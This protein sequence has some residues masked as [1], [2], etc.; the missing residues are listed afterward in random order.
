MSHAKAPRKKTAPKVTRAKAAASAPA[1]TTRGRTRVAPF[2]AKKLRALDVELGAALPRVIASSDDEAIHDLRV[3][4]RRLRTLLKL[5]RP[6]YG[7]FHAD[8]VRRAFT[9]IQ[10][11]T[12]DLRDEEVLEETLDELPMEDEG[13]VAWKARRKSRERNLRRA[14]VQRL[15]AGDLTR[16]RAMLR[17]L[18][19]LPVKPARNKDLARFARKCVERARVRVDAQ[20]DVDPSDVVGMHELRIA[21]KELR[22]SAELLCEALPLDLRVLSEPAA[23]FQK[24]LGEVHDV[25]MALVTARRARG[26]NVHV[27]AASI[28]LLEKL[29]DKKVAKYV[30]EM[31]PAPEISEAQLS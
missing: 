4:I 18:L 30:A 28:E 8:A 25:D 7:R 19:A 5:S 21:F 3:A 22:Y 10:S 1:P 24:R 9:E 17:G 6:V 11:A 20:R 16:A 31:V 26:L 14:V 27:R 13:F 23:K 29:R 15:R 2:V 12:G